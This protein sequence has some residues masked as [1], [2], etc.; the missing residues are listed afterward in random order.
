[1][2]DT[3]NL[4]FQ[5]CVRDQRDTFGSPDSYSPPCQSPERPC[6]SSCPTHSPPCSPC[7]PLNVPVSV[8]LHVNG[9]NLTLPDVPIQCCCLFSSVVQ[10]CQI[11]ESCKTCRDAEHCQRDEHC[12]AFPGCQPLVRMPNHTWCGKLEEQASE[13]QILYGDAMLPKHVRMLSGAREQEVVIVSR[14]VSTAK[15]SDIVQQRQ[16]ANA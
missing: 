16:A 11:A 14:T 13:C 15:V 10:L 7:Q 8:V 9:C 12:M 6:A 4:S 3:E 5:G 2:L 1:M